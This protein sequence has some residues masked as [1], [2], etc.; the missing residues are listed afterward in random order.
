MKVNL[1]SPNA[2]MTILLCMDVFY[3]VCAVA[4]FFFAP[5]MDLRKEL[6]GVFVG[7]NSALLIAL[8]VH[9]DIPKLPPEEK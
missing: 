2:A 9:G 8:R 7:F 4:S 3:F 1:T 5:L 6:W